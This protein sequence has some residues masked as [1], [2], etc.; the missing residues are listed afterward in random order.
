M[1]QMQMVKNLQW[2]VDY[3]ITQTYKCS[4]RKKLDMMLQKATI[5]SE[6]SQ[7]LI[8]EDHTVL[9]RQNM[10]KNIC[11]MLRYSQKEADKHYDEM[12]GT[13][14]KC[15]QCS[16]SSIYEWFKYC[17]NCGVKIEFIGTDDNVETN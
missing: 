3:L 13:L 9:R 7:I 11:K 8:R 17:P 6:M 16:S 15:P 4:D 5:Y 10:G 1:E 2:C 14:Y 12:R